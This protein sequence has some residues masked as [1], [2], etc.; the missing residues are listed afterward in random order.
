MIIIIQEKQKKR[1][2]SGSI[3][4]MIAVAEKDKKYA[5]VC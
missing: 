1:I 3:G 5:E 4:K 2:G